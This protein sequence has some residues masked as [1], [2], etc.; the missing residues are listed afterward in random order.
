MGKPLTPAEIEDYIPHRFENQLIDSAIPGENA[1]FSVSIDPND[2]HNRS[3]FLQTIEIGKP[4]IIMETVLVELLALGMIIKEGPTPKDILVFF[5]SIDSFEYQAPAIAGQTTMGSVSTLKKRDRFFKCH[6]HVEQSGE[7][8]ARATLMASVFPVSA[9]APEQSNPDTVLDFPLTMHQP[10]DK[11]HWR[12]HPDLVICDAIRLASETELIGEYCFHTEHPLI[13]GHF[14]DMPVMMGV[15]QWQ[16]V[17]DLALANA[18]DQSLSSP[19]PITHTYTA[20]LYN[21]TGAVISVISQ[22]VVSL[23]IG[24]PGFYPHSRIIRTNKVAFKNRVVPGDT[25]YTHAQR[26]D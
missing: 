6:G 17:A 21:Q 23:W 13:R 19:E 15:L 10:V 24:V 20:T 14:P 7:P 9:S 18:L 3:I 25:I 5:A 16:S 4:P 26:V 2:N 12:R 8:S 22:C 11:S 1:S